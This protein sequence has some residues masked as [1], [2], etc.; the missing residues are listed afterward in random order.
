MVVTERFVYVHMPKTGGSFVEAVLRRLAL[1][2]GEMH[3]DAATL[4][5]RAILGGQD[6]HQTVAQ[7][8]E[9]FRD[10]PVL[11]TIRNPFDHLVSFFTFGWWKRHVGDTFDEARIRARHPHY[12]EL[13]FDEY[14]RSNYDW[15]LLADSYA[16]AKRLRVADAGPLTWDY[17]RFLSAAPERLMESGRSDRET[18]IERAEFGKIHFLPMERLNQGL[19]EFLLGQGHSRAQLEFLLGMKKVYP[20]GGERR[21]DSHWQQWYTPDL[22]RLVYE[23]ERRLFDLFPGY[24]PVAAVDT[25]G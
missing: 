15:D 5:G 18:A 25:S 3:I 23:R 7:I 16:I 14:L 11:F 22:I 17:S 9:A 2:S 8:P 20:L 21:N 1:E 10:L 13:S 24:Q 4:Q 6:Q 12:P 19:H